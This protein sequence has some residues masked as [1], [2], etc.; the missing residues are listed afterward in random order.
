[1][2]S[3]EVQQCAQL[4]DI[5]PVRG[6]DAESFRT[7]FDHRCR[8]SCC[9]DGLIVQFQLALENFDFLVLL[10]EALLEI[11][12]VIRVYVRGTQ[13]DADGSRESGE[14]RRLCAT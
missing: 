12:D 3:I 6:A 1:M 9:G 13:N 14:A 8:R 10:I 5:R 11:R 4:E 2:T 7:R